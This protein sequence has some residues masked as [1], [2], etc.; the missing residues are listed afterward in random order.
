MKT[1]ETYLKESHTTLT[2]LE[3]KV[4]MIML[5]DGYYFDNYGYDDSGFLT[6]GLDGKRER[7]ALSSLVKKGIIEVDRF[8]GEEYINTN[9]D[10]YTWYKERA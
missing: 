10:L 6:Y 1:L 5:N 3:E 8:D 9:Y 2:E 7:G 4:L